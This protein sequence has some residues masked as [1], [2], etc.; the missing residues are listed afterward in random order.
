MQEMSSQAW[1]DPCEMRRV[2]TSTVTVFVLATEFQEV[3]SK[4]V[5]KLQLQHTNNIIR[6]MAEETVPR[7]LGYVLKDEQRK[8]INAFVRGNDVFYQR[9]MENPS[10]MDVYLSSF[11]MMDF[12][13]LL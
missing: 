9:G 4:N 13:L 12:H 6:V 5:I 8:V 2:R 10:A 3:M 1:P 11:D 7:K